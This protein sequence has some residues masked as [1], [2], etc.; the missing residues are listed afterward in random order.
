Q[1]AKHVSLSLYRRHVL[2]T[3][4]D[5]PARTLQLTAPVLSRVVANGKTLQYTVTRSFLPKAAISVGVRRMLRPGGRAR[6]LM[7]G[8]PAAPQRAAVPPFAT[9]PLLKQLSGGSLSAAPA[10]GAPAGAL[11]LAKW[12]ATLPANARSAALTQLIELHAGKRRAADLNVLRPAQ[13]DSQ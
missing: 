5:D 4:G 10:R 6:R 9:K 8:P 12:S 13:G 11:T 1:L 2:P 3:K 7:A